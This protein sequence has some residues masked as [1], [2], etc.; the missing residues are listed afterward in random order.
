MSP[1][2]L[3]I[4]GLTELRTVYRDLPDRLKRKTPRRMV[5]QGARVVLD[6]SRRRAPEHQGPYRRKNGKTP[7]VLKRS[8][9][10]KAA[11]ELNTVTQVGL[12]VTALR[13]KRFQA[14]GKKGVNKDAYYARWVHDGHRIVARGDG[15]RKT[16]GIRKA[17]LRLRRLAVQ[18]RVAGKPFLTDALSATGTAAFQRMA[19]VLREDL[20]SGSFLK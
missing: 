18:G 5:R 11:R 8:L 12:L 20:A 16:K 1:F 6:E 15:R 13:G 19:D 2:N 17:S 3:K 4:T 14:V 10:L 9:I 7:G